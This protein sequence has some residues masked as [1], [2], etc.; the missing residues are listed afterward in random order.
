MGGSRLP[1]LSQSNYRL[2]NEFFCFVFQA[3]EL[4]T[5]CTDFIRVVSEFKKISDSFS[6]VFDSVSQEVEKEKISA[7]GARNLLRTSTKNRESQIQQLTAL[8]IEKQLE[9]D[10]LTIEYNGLL[11]VESSQNEFME[12]FVLRK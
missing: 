7:I 9:V 3:A 2:G 10:R 1:N 6:T 12:Q 11:N 8:L 4:R 5:T